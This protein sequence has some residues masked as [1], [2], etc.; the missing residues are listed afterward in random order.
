VGDL[1]AAI[2]KDEKECFIQEMSSGTVEDIQRRMIESFN[3]LARAS[4]DGEFWM[5]GYGVNEV[6]FTFDS[7]SS[8]RSPYVLVPKKKI[9][10][11]TVALGVH[12]SSK[13]SPFVLGF[14]VRDNIQAATVALGLHL[15]GSML[16]IEHFL[17]CPECRTIFISNRQPRSDRRLHCSIKCSRGAASRRYREKLQSQDAERARAKRRYQKKIH[18]KYPKAPIGK[19][20][21]GQASSA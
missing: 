13:R 4:L 15:V 11:A 6:A 1:S 9:Q 18:E 10:P 5:G 20:R 12:C 3:E 14:G 8:L 2:E 19:R 16:T 21:S 7:N 17:R